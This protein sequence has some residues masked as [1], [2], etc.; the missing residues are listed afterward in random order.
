MKRAYRSEYYLHVRYAS[1]TY[2]VYEMKHWFLM[3]PFAL[4]GSW[5][6]YN[7]I[8]DE[9]AEIHRFH[10]QFPHMKYRYSAKKMDCILE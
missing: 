3:N 7:P 1:L 6:E 4:T 8:R 9:R 10:F 5:P 2:G